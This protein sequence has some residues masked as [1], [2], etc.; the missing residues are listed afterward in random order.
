MTVAEPGPIVFNPLDPAFRADP[1]PVYRRLLTEAPV[2]QTPLGVPA[3]SRFADCIAILKNHRDFSSDDRKSPMY[4]V[5]QASL[6]EAMGADADLF[7]EG[8]RPFLFMDP[9]D[10]TR[11]RRLVNLAFSAKAVEALRPRIQELVDGFLDRIE[12]KRDAEVIGDLAYPLPVAVI[13][14][15][16]GVPDE[17]RD[18]FKE[19]SDELVKSL[20]P[21]IA[22]TPDQIKVRME[23]V[24]RSRIYFRDLIARRRKTPGPDIVTALIQAEEEGD[25]LS[26]PELLATCRLLLVAGHETTVNLIGNAVLQL[27][28][29]PEELARFQA[30]PGGLAVSAI[31]EVLRFDPPVQ[32][33]GR[34]TPNGAVINGHELAPGSFV[35]LLL[36]AA[37]RDP[38]Q[39]PDPDRFDITRGDDRHLAFGYG[40]HFCLGAPLARMEG[41]VALRSLARRFK[42]WDLLDAAPQY[43]D[44]ITIRGLKSLPVAF[45]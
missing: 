32:F 43:K 6:K 18:E 41:Q 13:C 28:R 10:H 7:E 11:L 34:S 14:E 5:N 12:E 37:N 40:I 42:N 45:S 38:A 8:D 19:W 2:Y 36:G 25:K 22:L 26:E 35:L 21:G 15:M 9:P 24:R 4:A 33:D 29:H 16:L 1:Y 44:M 30:D 3:F 23:A 17:D 31:E 27:C 20:D 39:F